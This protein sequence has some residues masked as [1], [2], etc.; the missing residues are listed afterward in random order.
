MMKKGDKIGNTGSTGAAV[1]RSFTF[2]NV[3]SRN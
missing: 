2:W 1:W 3:G